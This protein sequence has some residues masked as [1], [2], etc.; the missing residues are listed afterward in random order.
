VDGLDR[1]RDFTADEALVIPLDGVFF[2]ADLAADEA[3][4]VGLFL[5][6]LAGVLAGVFAGVLAVVFTLMGVFVSAPVKLIS[7]I[8]DTEDLLAGIDLR[9]DAVDR[10]AVEGRAFLLVEADVE[11]FLAGV[12][13]LV[14][15]DAFGRGVPEMGRDVL[16]AGV[17]AILFVCVCV[18]GLEFS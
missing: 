11:L 15:L 7:L 14:A 4:A 2:V 16:L 3:L 12:G 5:A 9:L 6:A 17:L 10:L 1:D 13:V 18:C 8:G